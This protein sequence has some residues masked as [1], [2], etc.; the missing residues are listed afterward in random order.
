MAAQVKHNSTQ[1]AVQRSNLELREKK[2]A[3]LANRKKTLERDLMDLQTRAKALEA[4]LPHAAEQVKDKEDQLQQER[5]LASKQRL[6]IS[7]LQECCALLQSGLSRLHASCEEALRTVEQHEGVRFAAESQMSTAPRAV[8]KK[9]S[10]SGKLPQNDLPTQTSGGM[11]ALPLPP[12][13]PRRVASHIGTAGARIARYRTLSL[14]EAG[15][16]Q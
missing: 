11:A 9:R 2:S 15:S 10:R 13:V 4:K 12:P 8:A 7:R 1:L 14:A 5:T 3:A 6:H 16:Q